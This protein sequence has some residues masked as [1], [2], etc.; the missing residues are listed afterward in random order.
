MSFL[1]VL[2]YIILLYIVEMVAVN[3]AVILIRYFY[4]TLVTAPIPWSS[5]DQ[6]ILYYGNFGEVLI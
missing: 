6:I 5:S 3:S 4:L 1:T 2:E